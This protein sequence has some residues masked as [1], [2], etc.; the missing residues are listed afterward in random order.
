LG[1]E[2]LSDGSAEEKGEKLRLMFKDKF[3]L[4]SYTIHH[5]Q[6][7]EE[8]EKASNENWCLT[9]MEPILL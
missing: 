7:G 9:R 2:Y 8:R 5:L 4:L 3:R 6:P 1:L